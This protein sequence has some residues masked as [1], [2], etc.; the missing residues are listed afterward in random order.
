MINFEMDI[1]NFLEE[2]NDNKATEFPWLTKKRGIAHRR[3][4]LNEHG[5]VESVL[6]NWD[7]EEP[8][9]LFDKIN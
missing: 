2:E 6:E 5:I 3:A 4:A 7:Q 8:G 1:D 9:S